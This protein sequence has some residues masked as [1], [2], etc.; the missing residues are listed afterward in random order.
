M[1]LLVVLALVVGL[2][3]LHSTMYGPQPALFAESFSIAVRCSGVS[4]GVQLGS[5]LGGA[6][7]PLIAT[8]L[9]STFGS[10]APVAIYSALGCAITS[11]CGMLLGEQT[12]SALTAAQPV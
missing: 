1:N 11:V 9:L 4:S 12:R 2:G 8:A 7:A 10:T 5:L 6:F 3:L